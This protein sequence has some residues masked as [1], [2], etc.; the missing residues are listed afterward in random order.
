MADFRHFKT[1]RE[2]QAHIDDK[3]GGYDRSHMTIAKKA[4]KHPKPY[5]VATPLTHLHFTPD[6]WV[7]K[8]KKGKKR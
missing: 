2:A 3:S 7:K 5:H 1:R 8:P 6:A 4:C